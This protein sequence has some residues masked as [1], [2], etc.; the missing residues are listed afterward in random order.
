VGVGCYLTY[1]LTYL[2]TILPTGLSSACF[3]ADMS[4]A[5]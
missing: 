3:V 1:L 4:R 5:G 2:L